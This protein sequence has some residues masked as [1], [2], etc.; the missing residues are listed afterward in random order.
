LVAAGGIVTGLDGL[1]L[2]YGTPGL[3]IPSFLA[4]GNPAGAEKLG[5][6]AKKNTR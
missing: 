6:V 2:K 3:R 5:T 1:P 4:W